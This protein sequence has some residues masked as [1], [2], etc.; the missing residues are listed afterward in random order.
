MRCSALE[1]EVT[2]LTRLSSCYGSLATALGGY[3][4]WRSTPILTLAPR[5]LTCTT[6]H[7]LWHPLICNTVTHTHT[8][9]SY[10]LQYWHWL[11]M[12]WCAQHITHSVAP[13]DPQHCNTHSEICILHVAILTLTY[14]TFATHPTHLH[15]CNTHLKHLYP[16]LCVACCNTCYYKSI[17]VSLHS[18]TINVSFKGK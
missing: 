12:T 1:G 8:F 9:V 4:Q 18:K 14:L 10:M 6:H 17:C 2:K 16:T 3:K 7:T 15:H 13:T 11:Q 5:D